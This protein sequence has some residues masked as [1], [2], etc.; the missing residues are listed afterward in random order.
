[1]AHKARILL[2]LSA[3]VVSLAVSG[4]MDAIAGKSEKQRPARYLAVGEFGAGHF[5]MGFNYD[6][7]NTQPFLGGAALKFDDVNDYGTV[8]LG[9]R[10]GGEFIY[11]R[12]EETRLTPMWGDGGVISD[13]VLNGDAPMGTTDL[14]KTLVGLAA[15]TNA[16]IRF[17]YGEDERFYPDPISGS[18]DWEAYVLVTKQGFRDDKTGATSNQAGT[19]PYSP[20]SPGDAKVQDGQVELHVVL[21]NRTVSSMP[22]FVGQPIDRTSPEAVITSRDYHRVVDFQNTAIGTNLTLEFRVSTP[23][24]SLAGTSLRFAAISPTGNELAAATLG[25]GSGST[26]TKTV[27]IPAAEFGTYL[28]DISGQATL[29]Q[30]AI[31][32]TY[33]ADSRIVLNAWWDNVVANGPNASRLY[34][35][36]REQ[37]ESAAVIEG[38]EPSD[39]IPTDTTLPRPPGFRTAIVLFGVFGAVAAVL[40][41]TKMAMDS[42]TG[43]EFD[44]K[45]RGR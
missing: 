5:S 7:K 39:P 16:T 8:V 21:Q 31:K 23:A 37:I 22:S 9:G 17:G 38:G 1:M 24:P 45:I 18:Q 14:P 35:E 27:T 20:K 28:I 29:A 10:L 6:G 3:I 25:G 34:S 44:R 2:L 32:G 19:G 15:T 41:L 4:C 33:K 43:S 13:V 12:L 11:I 36:M 26:E 30:W 42:R 40:L